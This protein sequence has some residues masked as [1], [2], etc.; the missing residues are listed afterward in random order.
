[1]APD[2]SR[3]PGPHEPR[4]GSGP[5]TN[6][7][8]PETLTPSDNS[9]DWF[10]TNPDPIPAWC[11]PTGEKFGKYFESNNPATKDNL[12]NWPKFKYHSL[13]ATSRP[14]CIKYQSLGKCRKACFLAH[15]IP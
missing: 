5:A 9:P 8:T 13:S 12:S 7:T 14:L 1:M 10:T 3:Y 2:S 15:V 6:P 11:L 4:V